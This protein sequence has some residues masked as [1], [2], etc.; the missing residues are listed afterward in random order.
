VVPRIGGPA[1][2]VADRRTGFL[3]DTGDPARIAA[4]L[5]G[6]LAV[7]DDE[8]RAGSARDLVR[9]R[10]TIG[11]MAEAVEAVYAEAVG[12]EAAEPAIVSR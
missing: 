10:F 7:A 1:T 4:G 3:V 8:A 9:R 6:A 2:Y 12:V 5:H 11:A